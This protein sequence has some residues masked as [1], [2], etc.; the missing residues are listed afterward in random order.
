MDV[1]CING[2]FEPEQVR[3]YREH[4]VV[5]P[6]QDKLYTI[7]K[8]KRHSNGQVGLW[9]EELVNPPVPQGVMGIEAMMEPSWNINRFATLAGQP[10]KVKELELVDTLE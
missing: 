6:E 5:T 2:K 3:M 8:H 10:I 7:R 9:L 1:I 4:G